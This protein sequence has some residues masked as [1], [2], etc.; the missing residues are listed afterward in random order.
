MDIGAVDHVEFYVGDAQQSAF[1]LCTA[2]GFRVCGQAG[3]ETGQ[4]DHRS[5]LLRQGGIEI[6]LTSALSPGHPAAAYVTRHGDGVANIAFEV[7]D[8]AKA[9]ATA[10]ERGATP[11]NSPPSTART[12]PRWSPRRCWAS[13]T[14]PTGSSSAPGTAS[15]SCPA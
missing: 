8:A 6:V 15:S 14:S 11:S 9:F 10:V 13:E 1:Y 5:L 4:A 3:P 12:A 7:T 2:F